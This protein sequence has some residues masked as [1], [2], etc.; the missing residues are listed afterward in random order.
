MYNVLGYRTYLESYWFTELDALS[1]FP[2]TVSQF[3]RIKVQ[4]CY[5]DWILRHI[6]TNTEGGKKRNGVGGREKFLIPDMAHNYIQTCRGSSETLPFQ[7]TIRSRI[8]CFYSSQAF[9]AFLYQSIQ[10][11]SSLSTPTSI[12][13][14]PILNCSSYVIVPTQDLA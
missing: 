8:I 13:S 7:A 2:F 12:L 9:A 3:M 14:L 10:I 5:Q 11:T 4:P 1:H 6:L